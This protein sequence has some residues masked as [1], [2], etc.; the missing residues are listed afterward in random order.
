VNVLI[1]I[2]ASASNAFSGA[3]VVSPWLMQA[4]NILHCH[5]PIFVY[6]MFDRPVLSSNFPE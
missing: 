1:T 4:Y 5:L 6:G 3:N 2:L